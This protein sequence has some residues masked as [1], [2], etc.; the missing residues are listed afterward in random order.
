MGFPRVHDTHVSITIFCYYEQQKVPSKL[1]NMMVKHIQELARQ[2]L[3]ALRMSTGLKRALPP[4]YNMGNEEKDQPEP[5]DDS[6]I[7]AVSTLPRGHLLGR[8]RA[9]ASESKE[10]TL[11]RLLFRGS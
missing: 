1:E 3:L 8:G 9:L 5:P 10:G 4:M 11:R 6:Y 7:S 2:Q